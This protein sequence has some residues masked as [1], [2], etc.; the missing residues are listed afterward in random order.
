MERPPTQT[1][2]ILAALHVAAAASPD[3]SNSSPARRTPLADSNTPNAEAGGS[4]LKKRARTL[5]LARQVQAKSLGDSG[6]TADASFLS[7]SLNSSP[8]VAGGFQ[9]NYDQNTPLRAVD[10]GGH[11]Q[12][13]KMAEFVTKSL[14]NLSDGLT[15]KECMRELGLE[16]SQ[17]LLPGLEVRLMAHQAIGVAW[18]LKRERGQDKGGILAD[19]MGL[20]KTVQ[21]IATMAMNPPGPDEDARTTLIVVPA[22]LLQ[23]WKDEIETKTNEMFTVRLHHGKDKLKKTSEIKEYDVV[24]TTYQTLSMDFHIPKDVEADEETQWL[25]KHGGVLAKCRFYRAIADEAQ[26]IRNRSTKAS[27]SLAHVRAKYRWMLTGTPVTNTLAD[28]YGLLRFGRFRPWNDFNSF[29]EHVAKVQLSDAS[30]AGQRAQMIL[31]PL[32]LRRTKTS[33]LE[34]KPILTLPNKDIE[35]VRLKFTPEEREIYDSFEKRSKISLNRFIRAGTLVKNHAAVLVMIL[36]LRQLCCHPHLILSIAE[37]QGFGDPTLLMGSDT[38][39]ERGRALNL[40]G[41]PWVDAVKRRFLIRTSA[42]EMLDDEDEAKADSSNCPVCKDLFLG[43]NGR[44]LPCGHEICFDCTLDLSNSAIAHDGV[45]GEGSE[46]QNLAAEKAYEEAAAK[47][48]RPCPT[49]HKM[50]DLKSKKIF[51]SSAFDPTEDELEQHARSKRE[52]KRPRYSW[53]DDVSSSVHVRAAPQKAFEDRRID[54]DDD[55]DMPDVPLLGA[56]FKKEEKEESISTA[57]KWKGKGKTGRKAKSGDDEDDVDMPSDAVISNWGRGDDDLE[58]ST[59]MLE[60]MRLLKEWESTGD[61]TICYSQWTSMLDLIEILFTRHGVRSLRFDGKMDRAARD[62]VLATFKKAGGPKVIL[63]STKCGSV[64]LNLVSANRIIN[65]DLSWNAAAETQA[66]D[67]AHRIGQNKDVWV[68]RLVVENT[69]EERMLQL[70]DVKSGL[71]NAALG[72][73]NGA[74]LHKMSVKDIKQL[75]GMAPTPDDHD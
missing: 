68:K 12:E 33:T 22:A 17:D 64:G 61:K 11:D 43:D 28:I 32:L 30:L 54:S 62:A 59:K 42:T 39:K 1:S 46:K 36:R 50:T 21:M 9:L 51:K 55:D 24:I 6:A 72:E 37:G 3:A 47:G 8:V 7:S 4:N 58:P 5:D 20:G 2:R 34:G 75:F 52:A 27:L 53:S 60:M 40:M 74:S 69:I 23:Q 63:I 65:M 66:Y 29:N 38:E 31:K 13:E 10:I 56:L 14:D 44:V 16:N 35:I 45:F 18:M 15:V 41:K 19:D 49:C 70:Q 57:K 25:A 71:A 48:L 26:Y 73:G 67:R